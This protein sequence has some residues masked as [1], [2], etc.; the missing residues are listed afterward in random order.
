MKQFYLLASLCISTL[1][2]IGNGHSQRAASFVTEGNFDLDFYTKIEDQTVSSDSLLLWQEEIVLHIDKTILGP[3]D[4]LFFKAYILTGPEKLRVSASDVMTLELLD[5]QGALIKSQVHKIR[6]GTSQGSLELPKRIREGKY[7]IRTYTQWMLNYDLEKLTTKEILIGDNTDKGSSDTRKAEAFNIVPEGGRLI[8]GLK[9]RVIVLS[10]GHHL[11]QLSVV[12]SNQDIVARIKGFGDGLGS[13]ML[14]PE[15]GERYYIRTK[16]ERFIELPG[17]EENGYTLQVNNLNIEKAYIS[18]AVSPEKRDAPIYLKGIAHGSTYFK[19]KVDFENGDLAQIEIPKS[20]LPPGILEL[21]LEDEFAGIWNRRPVYVDQNELQINI[22]KLNDSSGVSKLNLLV[23]DAQGTPV[24]TSLSVSIFGTNSSESDRSINERD[25]PGQEI[26]RNTRFRND[27]QLLISN[28]QEGI[29]HSGSYGVPEKILYDFQT[30]LEFY[31]Q[32]YDL[33]NKL[34]TNTEIQVLITAGEDVIVK[35]TLTNADGLFK[36]SE[37]QIYGEANMIFRTAGEETKARLVKVIPYSYE[38][39]PL[40]IE[41]EEINVKSEVADSKSTVQARS[42]GEFNYKAN[43]DRIFELDPITLVATKELDKGS[44][45]IYNLQATRVI[46]Q[47]KEKPKPIPQLFLNI[48][49]VQVVGLGDLNPTIFIPRAAR[50]GPI[51]WVLDGFPL[52]QSTKLRDIISLVNYTDIERIELFIGAEASFYGSRAAGGVIEVYT[53]SGSDADYIG[54]KKGQLTFQG[55]HE[56]LDFQEYSRSLK[57]KRTSKDA[58][59]STFYWNPEVN[60]NENGKA[61]ILLDLPEQDYKLEIQARA[62]TEKGARG[63]LRAIFN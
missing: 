49:G 58:I 6:S 44:P 55:F 31:G 62:I 35:E 59:P 7:Y 53:R 20:D 27:L 51:L 11:D 40:R 1:L 48:P 56:S 9:S 36:L 19:M 46:S 22:E 57:R 18:I 32:A 45:S 24:Q 4:H 23:T 26:I 43:A 3:R 25:Y 10:D 30:G 61:F 14:R 29:E 41:Q 37:L 39:P 15:F 52:D 38:R 21:Q 33:N 5:A 13:F 8:N 42:L 28:T 17:V 63:E 16:D 47:D 50:L 60:T 2:C 12:N 54:R 34:L